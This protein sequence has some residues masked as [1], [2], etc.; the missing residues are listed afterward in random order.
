MVAH[1]GQGIFANNSHL[2]RKFHFHVEFEFEN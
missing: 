2:K 1:E